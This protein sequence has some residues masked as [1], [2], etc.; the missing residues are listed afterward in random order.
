MTAERGFCSTAIPGRLVRSTIS[1]ICFRNNGRC[2]TRSSVFEVD[3]D[4]LVP[5]LLARGEELGRID[6][7]ADTVR[8]RLALYHER[9]E[10]LV[11]LYR[12]RGQLISVDATGSVKQVKER[13]D[14][15]LQQED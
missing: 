15:A 11:D 4:E 3:D 5:R 6:D 10:P 9:T 8:A 14:A 13:I 1:I 7:Q 12:G 2:S